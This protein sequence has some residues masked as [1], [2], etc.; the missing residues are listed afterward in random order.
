MST[1]RLQ[2]NDHV[3]TISGRDRGKKGK[4]LKIFPKSLRAI[5]EGMNMLT[6]HQRPTRDNP[7]GGM[8]R[9][10]GTVHISNLKFVCPRC[11]KS[12][13]VGYTMLADMTKKRIC[14][15]CKEIV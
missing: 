9:R 11:N 8:I 13:R 4:V 7:K 1:I 15:R 14:K 6:K 12:T 10:E 5:V 2:R 3:V